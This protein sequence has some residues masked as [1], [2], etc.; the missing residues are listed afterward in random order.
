MMKQLLQKM[1]LDVVSTLGVTILIWN[2][3]HKKIIDRYII[4]FR[5]MEAFFCKNGAGL[6]KKYRF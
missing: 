6:K 2:K 5:A 3:K 1:H 4:G